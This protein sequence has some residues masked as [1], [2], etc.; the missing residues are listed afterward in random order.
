MLQHLFLCK[1]SIN[2]SGNQGINLFIGLIFVNFIYLK[3]VL[4]VIQST[5]Q[6]TQQLILEPVY[7]AAGMIVD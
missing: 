7:F 5:W 1:V 3:E 6:H 4:L 2:K